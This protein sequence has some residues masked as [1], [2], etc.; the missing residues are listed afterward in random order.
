VEQVLRVVVGDR[1]ERRRVPLPFGPCHWRITSERRFCQ[2]RGVGYRALI[3]IAND[4]I[5]KPSSV[6]NGFTLGSSTPLMASTS[7]AGSD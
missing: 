3:P 5:R 7:P 1:L 2:A 4:G 6:E